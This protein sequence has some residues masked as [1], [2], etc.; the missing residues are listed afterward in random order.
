MLL[1][2]PGGGAGVE[3][4]CELPN[5]GARGPRKWEGV[6]RYWKKWP[7]VSCSSSEVMTEG[8]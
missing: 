8:P 5:V 3:L 4:R 1:T 6:P 2:R 7:R